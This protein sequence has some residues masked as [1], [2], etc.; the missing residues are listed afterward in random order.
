MITVIAYNGQACRV[1]N[2][3]FYVHFGAGRDCL[4]I[5]KACER[6]V[7]QVSCLSRRWTLHPRLVFRLFFSLPFFFL[8]S[9]P[10]WFGQGLVMCVWFKHCVL[11]SVSPLAM[12]FYNVQF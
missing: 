7:C 12:Y 1:S 3:F 11:F 10:P 8:L 6:K 4:V 5:F 2:L 9:S